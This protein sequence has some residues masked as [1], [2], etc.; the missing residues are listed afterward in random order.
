MVTFERCPYCAGTKQAQQLLERGS[1]GWYPNNM[2]DHA[3]A[4]QWIGTDSNA[5][6][7]WEDCDCPVCNG[8]G[9]VD[10]EHFTCKVF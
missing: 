1:N 5:P 3:L 9:E 4:D 8:S 2:L 6:L 10:I 7:K